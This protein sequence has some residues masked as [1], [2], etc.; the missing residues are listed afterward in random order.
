[1]DVRVMA[2]VTAATTV[3]RL[4]PDGERVARLI[5]AAFVG[6]GLFV[7]GRAAAL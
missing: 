4:A 1:M 7:I 6:V 3:E 5:G 2:V